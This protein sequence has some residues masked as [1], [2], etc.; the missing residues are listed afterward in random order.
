MDISVILPIVFTFLGSLIG[1]GAVTSIVQHKLKKHDAITELGEK[2]NK[3]SKITNRN[4]KATVVVVDAVSVMIKKQ[5]GEKLN[6]ELAEA[7][8]RID[9]LKSEAWTKGL[10]AKDDEH[11]Q[12]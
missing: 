7:Q 11:E 12:A 3:L 9:K 2:I 10:F 8:G 5:C 1:S 4:S 6:G